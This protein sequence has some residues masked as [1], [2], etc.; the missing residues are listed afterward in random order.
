MKGSAIVP[1]ERKSDAWLM[2]AELGRQNKRM[3]SA[4][5]VVLILWAG[6]IGGFI[7]YLNQYDFSAEI[8]DVQQDASDGG[9]V[10]YIGND[11]DILNG[12]AKSYSN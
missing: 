5:I 11:G 6:T 4:L 1:E 12:E 9:D 7:W 3:F 8:Y 2:I 10:N